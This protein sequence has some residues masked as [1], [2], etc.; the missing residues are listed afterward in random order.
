MIL[1]ETLKARV[2]AWRKKGYAS[3]YTVISEIL[4][5]QK[6][7]GKNASFALRYLRQP[8]LEALETYWYLRIVE[9]TPHIFDLYQKEFE[10]DELLAA[11]GIP[12]NHT[13]IGKMLAR[14]GGVKAILEAIKRDD[15]FVRKFGL[16]AAREMMTLSYPSYI[17]A[18]AMGAGK[19]VLIGSIIATEFAMALEYPEGRFIRNALVFAPGKT[20][21]GALKELSDVPYERIPIHFTYTR[22]GEKDIPIIPRSSYNIIVTNTEKIRITKQSITKGQLGGIF[23]TKDQEESA[24][25]DVANQR[26][27][28]IA[29]LPHLGIFSDEAHHTYGQALDQELKQ[30]RKTVDYLAANTDVVAVVNTT[31]T[32]YYRRQLLKDVVYWY[33]LSQ[34]IKDGILKDVRDNIETY[35]NVTSRDF[36]T[37]VVKD[38]FA[39]YRDTKIYDTIPAKLA[40]YF[41]QTD[42]VKEAMP[43]VQKTLAKM[44]L[45]PS[46]ALAVTNESDE[47]TKDLFNNR[48]NDRSTAVRVFLLVNMGTEGWN[49]PSLFATALAREIRSSNNFVLQA[50]SRC[51]RQVPG[52]NQKAKI[53]LSNE[54]VRILDSEL[55]ETYGE[56]L[57][58]LTATQPEMKKERLVIRKLEI[59]PLTMRKIIHRIVPKNGETSSL[60]IEKPAAMKK[61]TRVTRY[62]LAEN[63]PR[64]RVLTETESREVAMDEE[65]MSAAELSV[66]LA[67]VCHMPL[68]LLYGEL[69]ALYGS[70]EISRSEGDAIRQQLETKAVRYK[71]VAEEVEVALA[72]I[73][74][75]GFDKEGGAHPLYVTEI[76]Y[77][78][79]KGNL[80][81]WYEVWREHH[82]PKQGQ[83]D[84]GFHYTPYNFD[85]SPEQDFFNRMLSALEENPADVAD[86]YFTGAM[87]DPEKTDFLFQ[88]QDKDNVWHN[89]APDFLIRKKSGK[90]LIVE[91]K[92]EDRM[93]AEKTKL[94]EKA[95]REIEGVNADA[96]KYEI[97]SADHDA[98]DFSDFEKIKKIV[99]GKA[100]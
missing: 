3:P 21:L 6:I 70:G 50:A 17:L 9:K 28:T 64:Q 42:D 30:V 31:G 4:E 76:Q 2:D 38:F 49:V 25:E 94:K 12:I 92:G 82:R 56:T 27:K 44:G 84:L 45:D 65:M 89:Y 54:N 32:P 37:E 75:E 41:P 18:L 48:V 43:T 11:L 69:S 39:N 99:Y 81:E 55:Q 60:E 71:T 36:A 86:I 8:Q 5:W 52:N 88:Y 100:K 66:E 46:L 1:H 16:N 40:I 67:A 23:G 15:D 61:S 80:L 91:V 14:G 47:K 72:L 13:E 22:D 78:A 63:K 51:L 90:M 96:V 53:Y 7:N 73:R 87:D 34:G 97:I 19:T 33:G 24:K 35:D 79:D 29:S 74:K 68:S 77:R 58:D 26:L 93:D 98:V 20:I 62:E 85:S 95:M 59:P 83:L 10:A 57:A